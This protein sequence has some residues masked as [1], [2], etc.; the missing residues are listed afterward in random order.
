MDHGSD[1]CYV[2]WWG[3]VVC[4]CLSFLVPNGPSKLSKIVGRVEHLTSLLDWLLGPAWIPVSNI[5]ETNQDTLEL[6]RGDSEGFT[7]DLDFATK[8]EKNMVTIFH[9][10]KVSPFVSA[11]KSEQ[12]I[13]K[14][15]KMRYIGF[16]D[17]VKS[18]ISNDLN[19][20]LTIGKFWEEAFSPIYISLDSTG[21]VLLNMT[22]LSLG[23]LIVLYKKLYY[24]VINENTHLL[25]LQHVKLFAFYWVMIRILIKTPF[26][27]PLFLS[28]YLP[29]KK[30]VHTD[31]S[32][33]GPTL[34]HQPR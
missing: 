20:L 34:W 6:G 25:S 14:R 3:L 1:R 19:P 18:S 26:C 21:Y 12:N 33:V 30:H 27:S 22:F 16:W 17:H 2:G 5:Q 4:S 32:Q 23:M 28:P 11:S 10:L 9:S 29:K 15:L 31:T 7:A 8:W 24:P 13:W